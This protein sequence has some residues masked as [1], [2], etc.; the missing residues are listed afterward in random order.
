M[1]ILYFSTFGYSLKIWD[2]SGQLSRE[3]KHF[4]KIHEKNN[5]INFTIITY[6]DEG[7]EKLIKNEFIKVIPIYKYIKKSNY[8]I[9]NFIKSFFI[10]TIIQK[11]DL[12]KHEILIQ[13]QLLGFWVAYIFKLKLKIPLIIRTGYD[14]YEFAKLENKSFF[15]KYFFKRLTI[16]G[17]SCSDIYTVTS[18]CDKKFLLSNFRIKNHSKV[19]IRP[20]WVHLSQ[21]ALQNTA[22]KRSSKKFASVGRLEKQKNYSYIIEALEGSNY[23]LDIYGN[24]TLHNELSKLAEDLNVNVNFLGIIENEELIK[25]LRDYKYY[26]TSS[27]FEG[28]PKSTLEAM[29]AGCLIIASNIKNHTE[30]LNNE[31]SIL[32]S[33][34]DSSL[35]DTISKLDTYEKKHKKIINNSLNTLEQS[36]TLDGLVEKELLDLYELTN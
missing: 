1:N 28:N 2:E 34:D 8:K 3:V 32:F 5:D 21:E 23:S 20:N 7:D 29:S 16:L 19:R 13:N 22:N 36:Y 33:N 17:L 18:H 12:K 15:K 4:S 10:F 25:R 11:L 26:I 35:K 9:V 27:I 6:G 30:F 14:M 31:N 24:G